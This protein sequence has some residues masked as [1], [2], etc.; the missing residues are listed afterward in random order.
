MVDLNLITDKILN[1][2]KEVF[3]R[4]T[5]ESEINS[6]RESML[7]M[8]GV[9]ADKDRDI[10]IYFKYDIAREVTF[11]YENRNLARNPYGRKGKIK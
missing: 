7:R 11:K 6:W 8:R 2:F 9:L 4:S 10:T 1:R 5:C 3:H